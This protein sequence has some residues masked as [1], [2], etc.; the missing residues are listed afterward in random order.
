M[1]LLDPVRL[2]Y[3]VELRYQVN[4]PGSDFIFNVQAARTARQL[5]L[6]ESLHVNQNVPLQEYCDPS[7]S[8]RFLRLRAASG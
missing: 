2:Q 5:V 8:G 7:T 1:L 6:S 3:R 4:S